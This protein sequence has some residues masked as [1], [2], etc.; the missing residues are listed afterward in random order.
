[1]ARCF[2]LVIGAVGAGLEPITIQ[3]D[4]LASRQLDDPPLLKILQGDRDVGTPHPKHQRQKLMGER[5]LI[6]V[7]TVIGHEQPMRQAPAPAEEG[8][9]RQ[10]LTSLS[11]N[12]HKALF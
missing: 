2:G 11:P 6:T 12:T 10:T 1:M 3:D 5:Y 4:D 8:G 7:K 9:V